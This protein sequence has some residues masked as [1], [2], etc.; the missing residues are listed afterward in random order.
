MFGSMCCMDYRF[1]DICET[2]C[3]IVFNTGCITHCVNSDCMRHC[4]YWCVMY[5]IVCLILH[6]S[7]CVFA[8]SGCEF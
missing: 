6:L 3:Y 2:V 7:H 1:S 8:V 5:V 4:V